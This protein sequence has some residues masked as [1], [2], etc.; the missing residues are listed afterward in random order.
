MGHSLCTPKLIGATAKGAVKSK[1]VQKRNS[2][3]I[4]LIHNGKK[5]NLHNI[6]R[7]IPTGE[8]CSTCK[9]LVNTSAIPFVIITP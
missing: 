6:L 3:I 5:I 7:T 8:N 9:M 2:P 4:Y 1:Q